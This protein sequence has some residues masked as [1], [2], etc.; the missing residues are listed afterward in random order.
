MMNWLLKGRDCLTV[1]PFDDI[2]ENLKE[3]GHNIASACSETGRRADEVVLLGVTK[4]VPAEAVNMAIDA[5]LKGIGENRVQE[6]L[7]KRE[8]LNF[9]RPDGSRVYA[10]LIG[11]LQ[12]NKV[13]KIVGMVDM[14]QSVDSYHIAEA[15]SEQSVKLGIVSDILIEVNSGMEQTKS[16]VNIEAALEFTYKLSG[17]KGIHVCGIMSIPPIFDTESQKRRIFSKLYKLF[18]DIRS[19]NIDNIDVSVLS[20]GMS[21]DYREAVLEGATMVRIGSAI[22]GRRA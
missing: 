1:K 9:L 19:K 21:G 15:I 11:H 17:L 20:M 13:P 2:C 14:I 5:G 16:G 7:G 6:Y 4:T 22:F 3:I 12:T 8:E 18:I 10:H